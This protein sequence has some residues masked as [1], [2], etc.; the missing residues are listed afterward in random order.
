MQHRFMISGWMCMEKFKIKIMQMLFS[1]EL[2]PCDSDELK[3]RERGWCHDFVHEIITH[4]KKNWV[5]SW[6][7]R[8][9]REKRDATCCC[10]DWKLSN[11]LLN[12][13]EQHSSFTWRSEKRSSEGNDSYICNL[14]DE[15]GLPYGKEAAVT[16]HQR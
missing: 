5:N 2:H 7:K 8:K 16:N 15:D 9:R 4:Y 6:F 14:L 1:P 11:A 10:F 12:K 13:L 3:W